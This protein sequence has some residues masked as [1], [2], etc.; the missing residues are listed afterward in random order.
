MA[1]HIQTPWALTLFLVHVS[2]WSVYGALSH[3]GSVHPDM[4]EAYLWGH[5][6]Q[7]GYFKHPPFWAWIAGAWFEVFPRSNWA[8][9]LL[10]S[11]NSGLAVL[12]VWRLY[13]LYAPADARRDSSRRPRGCTT[14]TSM[15]IRCS[16]APLGSGA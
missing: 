13:G 8:F 9:Y 7:L 2:V 15:E 12:G 10:C 1:R 11:L 3:T 14:P 4:L 16:T 5:E 6:F